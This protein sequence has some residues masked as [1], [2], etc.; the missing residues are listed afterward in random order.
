MKKLNL[1][2]FGYYMCQGDWE[3]AS[4]NSDKPEFICKNGPS[5]IWKHL[6]VEMVYSY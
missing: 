3:L 6:E 2:E 5:G 1:S 4:K